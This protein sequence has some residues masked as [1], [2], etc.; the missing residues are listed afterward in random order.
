MFDNLINP[1]ANSKTII[2]NVDNQT[3][4]LNLVYI[5]AQSLVKKLDEL[6]YMFVNSKFYCISCGSQGNGGGL[7]IYD[8]DS[9]LFC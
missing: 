3:S 6:R 5:K 8:D 2:Q 7:A 4:G 1:M 9:V